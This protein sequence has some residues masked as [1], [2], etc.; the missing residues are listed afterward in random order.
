MIMAKLLYNVFQNEMQCPLNS[1]IIFSTQLVQ[2]FLLLSNQSM[3][4]NFCLVE[5]YQGFIRFLTM[6]RKVQFYL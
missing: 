6:N 3:K 1:Y 4:N 2:M 5:F